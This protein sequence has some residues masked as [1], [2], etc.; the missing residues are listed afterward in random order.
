MATLDPKARGADQ[1]LGPEF[2][3]SFTVSSFSIDIYFF[4]RS[5]K[6]NTYEDKKVLR[7]DKVL[8]QL[9]LKEVKLAELTTHLW[10]VWSLAAIQDV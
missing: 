2:V 10:L 7:L 3:V 1:L 9:G 5:F 4:Q 6:C 8:D